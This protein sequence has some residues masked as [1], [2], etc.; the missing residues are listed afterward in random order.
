LYFLDGLSYGS[1]SKALSFL[2][3]VKRSQVAIWKWIQKY[4]PQKKI[5]TKRKMISKYIIVV[6]ETQL[7]SGS[8]RIILVM[9]DCCY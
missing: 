2:N 9:M 5:L 8:F 6:D 3:I 4:K 1:T 7:K